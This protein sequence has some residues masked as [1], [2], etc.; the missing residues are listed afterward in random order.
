MSLRC[1]PP[2]AARRGPAHPAD[3]AQALLRVRAQQLLLLLLLLRRRRR[4]AQTQPARLQ[5]LLPQ[6]KQRRVLH[7][8]PRDQARLPQHGRRVFFC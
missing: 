6:R 5:R 1:G 7:A 3:G 2:G 8:V 4:S